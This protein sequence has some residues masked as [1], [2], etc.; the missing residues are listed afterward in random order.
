MS[1]DVLR[2]HEK[3]INKS[4]KKYHVKKLRQE[5]QE[6]INEINDNVGISGMTADHIIEE[7]ADVKTMIERVIL[8]FEIAQE[9][10]KM[11]IEKMQRA[12]KRF[13]NEG[14]INIGYGSIDV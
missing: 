1:E 3:L 8:H 14:N 2:L 6:L 9:I 10:E 4:S 13:D 7:L 12:L 11:Q 5:C